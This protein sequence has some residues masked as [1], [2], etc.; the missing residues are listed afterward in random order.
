M[1]STNTG[2]ARCNFLERD[3]PSVAAKPCT[4]PISSRDPS[5]QLSTP[6]LWC[7]APARRAA[8]MT[9]HTYLTSQPVVPDAIPRCPAKMYHA[10]GSDRLSLSLHL[11]GEEQTPLEAVRRTSCASITPTTNSSTGEHNTQT[12]SDVAGALDVAQKEQPLLCR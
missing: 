7:P 6:P 11:S 4:H 9:H 8:T 5:R 12:C 10:N 2:L 3:H 1:A